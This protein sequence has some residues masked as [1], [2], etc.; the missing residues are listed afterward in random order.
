[1]TLLDGNAL[2]GVLADLF[3]G[4]PTSMRAECAQ[5]TR[6]CVVA[7]MHV[8]L[9]SSSALAQCP[10]CGAVMLDV[11]NDAGGTRIDVRGL[12]L[13]RPPTSAS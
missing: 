7:E 3:S 5:C 10:S 9:E 12:C 2:A 4:D 13:L 8:T 1:M 6:E 11:R